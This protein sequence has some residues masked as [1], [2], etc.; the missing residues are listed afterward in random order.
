MFRSGSPGN[1]A[2]SSAAGLE[3]IR[4][5]DPGVIARVEIV[6]TAAANAEE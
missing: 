5:G 4:V 2:F 1:E 6:C 3:A